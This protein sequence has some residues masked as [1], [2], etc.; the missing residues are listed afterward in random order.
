LCISPAENRRLV[1]WHCR[2]KGKGVSRC[3]INLVCSLVLPVAAASGCTSAADRRQT[4][5][6]QQGGIVGGERQERAERAL[7]RLPTEAVQRPLTIAVLDNGVAAAFSWRTGQIFVTRGLI[8]LVN[9]DELA[10]A[11][12]HE[13]GHLLAQGQTHRPTSLNG[14]ATAADEELQADLLAIDLL[15]AA[16]VPSD[17][18]AS[19][20]CKVARSPGLLPTCQQGLHQR[21]AYLTSHISSQVGS[22]GHA[23]AATATR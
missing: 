6:R 15:R 4:W 1:N 23:R 13:L 22:P 14:C 2:C 19:L 11:M 17:A 16:D 9:D 18:M 10:A 20:L 3:W 12:A 7:R 21:I 8:D 5:V